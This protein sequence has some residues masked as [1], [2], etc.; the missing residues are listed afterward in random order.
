MSN[1]MGMNARMMELVFNFVGRFHTFI[2]Q[3][4]L[5]ISLAKKHMMK[6]V[7]PEAF[8]TLVWRKQWSCDDI[9]N[10][11]SNWFHPVKDTNYLNC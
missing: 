1:A 9:L 10:Q 2:E 8:K 3:E 4:V 7:V 11:K 5:F 6:V